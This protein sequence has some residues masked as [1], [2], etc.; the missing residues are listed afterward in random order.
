MNKKVLLIIAGHDFQPIEYA[1]SKKVLEQAGV[2]VV[3]ASSVDAPRA[4]DGSSAQADVLVEDVVVDNYDGV[5]LIG[6]P[7]ALDDLDNE[8]IHSIMKAAAQKEKLYGA[9]CIS[10]RIL[11]GVGLLRGK[12]ATGWNGDNNLGEILQQAGA[13]YARQDTV[14]DG[15]VITASGPEAAEEFGRVIAETL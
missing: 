9:I 5:F 7:G 10:P 15:N 8:K 6:G 13:E 3:T 4:A 12:K 11:A 1:D 14:V 2:Q